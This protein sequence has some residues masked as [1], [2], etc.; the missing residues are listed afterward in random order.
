MSVNSL[1]GTNSIRS[2]LSKRNKT[3]ISIVI[4]AGLYFILYI[5]VGI[6]EFDTS[7]FLFQKPAPSH[8]FWVAMLSVLEFPL[9]TICRVVE[10][11]ENDFYL[12]V[13]IMNSFLWAVIVYYGFRFIMRKRKPV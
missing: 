4:L 1:N 2:K 11:P 13:F 10:I 7:S 8:G 6:V 9:I 5:I 12:I 3:I